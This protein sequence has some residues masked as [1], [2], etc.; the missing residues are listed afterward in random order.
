M[1]W[2]FFVGENS[3]YDGKYSNAYNSPNYRLN[4]WAMTSHTTRE[5][6]GKMSETRIKVHAHLRAN[7]MDK[8]IPKKF[9]T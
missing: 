9:K 6:Y 2:N 8:Y 4:G 5:S 1:A 7:N 3:G